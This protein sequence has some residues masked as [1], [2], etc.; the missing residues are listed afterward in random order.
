MAISAKSYHNDYCAILT[1]R[2]IRLC[3]GFVFFWGGVIGKIGGAPA[4]LDG[5]E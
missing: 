5:I 4:V 3:G 2:G 1:L